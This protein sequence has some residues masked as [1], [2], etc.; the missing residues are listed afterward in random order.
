V[1]FLKEAL[2][3]SHLK[4]SNQRNE[5]DSNNNNNTNNNNTNNN[6]NNNNSNNYCN[7]GNNNSVQETQNI[8]LPLGMQPLPTQTQ[9]K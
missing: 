5:L 8:N 1:T 2:S 4:F 7:N 6:N 9:L 3:S